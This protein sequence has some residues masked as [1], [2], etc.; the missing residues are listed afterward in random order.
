MT[1]GV[2]GSASQAA[3]DPSPGPKVIGKPVA[4]LAVLLTT[5]LV[6]AACGDDGDEGGAGAARP[7]LSEA[8]YHARA[9]EI[10][11]NGEVRIKQAADQAL[12]DASNTGEV[13]RFVTGTVVPNIQRQ[14]DDLRALVP[15]EGQADEFADWLDSSQAALERL[16]ADP[17]D[18]FSDPAADPFAEVNAQAAEL[19]LGEC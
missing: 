8:E 17:V 12:G 13:E 14:I 15:P 11:R 9:N 7:A 5:I 18:G 6:L 2:P 10:C 4:V 1:R 16:E 19:G 3:P